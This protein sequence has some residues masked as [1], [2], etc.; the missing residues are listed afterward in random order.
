MSADDLLSCPVCKGLP[1]NLREGVEKFYGKVDEK[2]YAKLLSD[3]LRYRWL[4]DQH[5]NGG[6]KW[7]VYGVH[8][9]LDAAIDAA[10]EEK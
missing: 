6:L 7:F 2:E 9:G 10:K 4:R 1:E 3:A 8:G 5:D